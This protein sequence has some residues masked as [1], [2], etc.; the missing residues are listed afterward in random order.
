[1]R[2]KNLTMRSAGSRNTGDLTDFVLP[3]VPM[4]ESVR[5]SVVIIK[6]AKAELGMVP[7]N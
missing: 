7:L 6:M 1:L 4:A 5:C 2:Y 3:R